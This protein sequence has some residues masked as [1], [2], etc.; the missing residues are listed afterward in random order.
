MKNIVGGPEVKSLR[1]VHHQSSGGIHL[2][3][4]WIHSR[5][6]GVRPSATTTQNDKTNPST[7]KCCQA[8]EIRYLPCL[9]ECYPF[10][11]GAQ[12]HYHPVCEVATAPL[13]YPL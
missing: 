5:W 9:I 4:G 7:C 1:V 6:Y 11:G 13:S 12:Y 8:K 2:S 3:S 10:I